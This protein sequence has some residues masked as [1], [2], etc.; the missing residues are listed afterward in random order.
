MATWDK[1]KPAGATAVQDSDDEIR[2]NFD[3]LEDAL[4]REH[5]FAGTYG[6][7]AGKHAAITCTTIVSTGNVTVGGNLLTMGGASGGIIRDVQDNFLTIA[8][9]NAI[10]DGANIA[11]YGSTHATYPGEAFYDADVHTFRSQDALT[12]YLTI[13]DT[14]ANIGIGTTSPDSKAILDLTST[15]QGFLVPRMTS[16]QRINISAP[17]EGMMVYDTDLSKLCIYTGSGTVW[18]KVDVTV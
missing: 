18:W 16:A 13:D 9:G 4:G 6:S 1:T 11:L 17:Q 3:A 14:Y 8:G 12:T 2:D 5:T 10:N 15:T 7:T